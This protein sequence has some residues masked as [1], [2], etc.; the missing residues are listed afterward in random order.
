MTALLCIVAA[1]F[2][3]ALGLVV[4]DMRR[5]FRGERGTYTE[6]FMTWQRRRHGE[7]I[8]RRVRFVVTRIVINGERK[9]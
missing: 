1:A 4:Q 3:L 9:L 8:L 7:R 2:V 5:A 6:A